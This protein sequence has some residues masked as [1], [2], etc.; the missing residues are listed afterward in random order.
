MNATRTLLPRF[1]EMDGDR[2]LNDGKPWSDMDVEDLRRAVESNWTIE[3]AARLLCR[4][5]AVSEVEAKALELGL[6]VRHE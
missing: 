6:P 4:E 1:T 5:T 2:D 3:D